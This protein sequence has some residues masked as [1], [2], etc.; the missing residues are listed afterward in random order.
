MVNLAITT[1]NRYDLLRRLLLSVQDSTIQP[2]SIFIIDNGLNREMCAAAIKD[3]NS[4]IVV[5][6]EYSLSLAASLNWFVLNVPEERVILHDDVILQPESLRKLVET[7]GD[8]VLDSAK[9]CIIMRDSCVEKVG[10]LDE[11][12]SPGYYMYEDCDYQHRMALAGIYPV[13]P[14]CDVIH[15]PSRTF[16]RTAENE[17][18]L[19]DHHRKFII[20]QN[21]YVQ[22]WGQLPEI[23]PQ[24]TWI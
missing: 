15:E 24:G 11:T 8:Y 23:G 9:G 21:N 2:N 6:L 4:V 12:I 14:N 19:Q 20:A 13:M 16:A 22:K 17:V 18:T 7:P 5:P 10:L 3:I 1:L